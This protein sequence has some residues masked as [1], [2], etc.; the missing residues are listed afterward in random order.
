[1]KKDLRF[2][3]PEISQV[4]PVHIIHASVDF[5]QIPEL[6]WVSIS[7]FY[8]TKVW[9]HISNS[10]ALAQIFC[11]LYLCLYIKWEKKIISTLGIIDAVG[12]EDTTG[13]LKIPLNYCLT[14]GQELVERI[15][16]A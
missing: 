8:T 13:T 3:S 6:L 10:P 12:D 11:G 2:L 16:L 1:M 14:L 9:G 4:T 5:D 15:I 7:S